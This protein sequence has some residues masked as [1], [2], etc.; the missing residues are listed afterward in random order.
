MPLDRITIKKYLF[1]LLG[2]ALILYVLLWL[3]WFVLKMSGS[4]M[5]HYSMPLVPNSDIAVVFGGIVYPNQE[6]TETNQER[7]IAAKTLLDQ[8]KVDEILI[9]NTTGA[10][11]VMKEYLLNLGVSDKEIVIDGNAEVTLDTC[12][13]I[14]PLYEDKKFVFVSHGY[15]LPRVIY[16]CRGVG[17][18][19]VG[20]APDKSNFIQRSDLSL[21]EKSKIKYLRNQREAVLILSSILG[22]YQ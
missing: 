15:H 3:P 14:K 1:K 2:S 17:V 10:S 12:K 16:Q 6:L 4:N 8:K 18:Q 5:M 13:N 21:I 20:F 7:L 9:S 22:F 11:L 19:G